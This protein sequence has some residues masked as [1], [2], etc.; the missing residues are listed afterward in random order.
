MGNI[1]SGNE[2]INRNICVEHKLLPLVTGSN[3]NLLNKKIYNIL[4]EH[5]IHYESKNINNYF[6]C[7]NIDRNFQNAPEINWRTGKCPFIKL[8][9]PN[10]YHFIKDK[11]DHRYYYLYDNQYNNIFTIFVKICNYDNFSYN[12]T[13][14]CIDEI[15]CY[16]DN[17]AR[18]IN[19]N[20]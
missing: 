20:N 14:N 10:G 6:W 3:A 9:L 19:L 15:K 18:I 16:H 12:Y 17:Y 2:E 13:G 8:I 1:L 7:P 4:D 5:N 11:N